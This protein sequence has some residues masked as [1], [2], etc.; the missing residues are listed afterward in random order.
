[1]KLSLI[2]MNVLKTPR[3]NT[4]RIKAL[5]AEAALQGGEIVVL[6]EMCCCEYSNNAFAENAMCSNSDFILSL[7]DI[8]KEQGVVLVAGS[9]PE[10][11]SGRIYNTSFVFDENGSIIAKH[12]KVHLFDINVAG[13]ISFKESD[14]FTAGDSFTVFDTKWGKIGLIICFDIRFPEF[15][16]PNSAKLKMI[17]VPASFNMTTG[18]AHWELL[19][20]ARAV[21]NQLFMAG[22]AAALDK[23]AGYHSYGHSIITDPWGKTIVQLDSGEAVVTRELDLNKVDEIRQQLP[24]YN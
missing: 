24:L 12:R 3:E 6:P 8:A 4:D 7:S 19:F 10:L 22:C 16:K 17:I 15:I 14:T 11:D 9:V 23:S 1:M 5:V 13:K 18:P 2:Q 20:K 21:D